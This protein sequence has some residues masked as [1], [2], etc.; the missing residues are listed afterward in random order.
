MSEKKHPKA[1][2]PS[3]SRPKTRRQARLKSQASTCTGAIWS[4]AFAKQ[5]KGKTPEDMTWHT[6]EDI[7]IPPVFAPGS[8]DAPDAQDPPWPGLWPY[9]R[10]IYP[11]MYAGRPWT[12]RQ[13]AGFS[14]P[15]ESNAFYKQALR[16][17]QT[18]LSVAFDLPTHRGYDSDHPRVAGDVGKAGVAIDSAQDMID[19]FDGV[20]LADVSVSMTMNGAALPI[21]ACF[22]VA[23]QT[24]GVDPKN[25]RGTIQNDILK[26][27]LVRNTY[28]YPV[29]D[30]M[31]ITADIITYATQVM[32]Q[33]HPISISGYHMQE[34]GATAVQELAY[35]IGNGL[36]YVK[37][38]QARG[39]AVD[40]FAPRLSFFFGIGMNL[41]MEVA[42]LRAARVLWARRM[43]D[44]FAAQ[45]PR[46]WMLK[47]HC[48]TSGVSLTAQDPMNNIIRTTIEAL[49]AV[50]GGTQ[51]L[52]TN[53]FDEA[54][55]LPS[56]LAAHTARATQHILAHEAG[57][58]RVADPLGGSYYIEYLTDQLLSKAEDLLRE[59]DEAGG[60]VRA[61]H[62]GIPK[63]HIEKSALARQIRVDS[64]EDLLV[65]V[66][67]FS[68]E[69][70]QDIP[71]RT[72]D[73]TAVRQA[74]I[75]KLTRLRDQ[76]DE[77]QVT[78]ALDRLRGVAAKK[79]APLMPAAIEAAAARATIGEMSGALQDVF[80]R[81]QATPSLVT[82]LWQSH[83][84]QNHDLSALHQRVK[85]FTE[86]T[87][88]RP[89]ILV[90]KLGQDGHDRGAKIIGAAF[91]DMGFDVDIGPLFQTPAE[92]ARQAVDNDVHVVGISS[93]AA[94]HMTLVPELVTELKRLSSPALTV[95]GGIIPPKDHDALYRSGVA[96]I[97]T[98]GVSMAT[99]VSD[100]LDL[101]S[102][103]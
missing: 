85:H 9:R 65:G 22:I 70:P 64:G 53:G 100:V 33:F 75:D 25:L 97:F 47:T 43:K 30:S 81:H 13:Y 87:G 38:A 27:F 2:S 68:A 39:L 40:D 34:A 60:M 41:F 90:A 102:P 57:M 45:N 35:T 78:A 42:K 52:H 19:L 24:Q 96:K 20:P 82:G 71:Q 79:Q 69:D 32:P 26:E 59:V 6:P 91:A 49:A 55:A 89:R 36:A 67:A 21:L 76:R 72:I 23:G 4:Q 16:G 80:G 7:A 37:A 93:Q 44:D 88:R 99:A 86:R 17:G 61:I 74:Q 1:P 10:G 66:N 8:P 11:S 101:L 54:L 48:Q 94:G 51:S 84:R 31:R 14:T 73:N 63:N 98:P 62:A 15:E 29:E 28:I 92:T 95:C 83:I 56:D 50:L 3:K 46:S 5:S 18:G 103:S 12:I 58:T 77:T